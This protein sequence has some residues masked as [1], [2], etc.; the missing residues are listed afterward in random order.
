MVCNSC[1]CNR[2]TDIA[3]RGQVEMWNLISIAVVVL[4]ILYFGAHVVVYLL[5]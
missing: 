5:R 3:R 2:A 4:A 1:T